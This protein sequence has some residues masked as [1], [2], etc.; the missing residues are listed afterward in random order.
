MASL[1]SIVAALLV[2]LLAGWLIW[3]RIL[4]S[5]RSAA[6][7]A[8]PA[9]VATE[10]A[11][12]PAA[13]SAVPA[14]TPAAEVKPAPAATEPNVETPE[15]AGKLPV[16][17]V[18][19]IAAPEPV[20]AAEP[21]AEPHPVAAPEPVAPAEPVAKPEPVAV[22]EPVAIAEPIAKPEPVAAAA[23]PALAQP[24]AAEPAAAEPVAAEPA[25]AEPVAAEPVA[26]PVAAAEPA[27]VEPE[28]V[29]AP[30]GVGAGAARPAD[31]LTRIEG[32]GPKIAATLAAAGISTYRDLAEADLASL[33]ATIKAAKLRLSPNLATW[34]EQARLLA[35]GD[36]RA[37][38]ALADD[39]AADREP[40]VEP[41]AT[42][43]ATTPAADPDL[44]AA[45]D[46]VTG[47]E[48]A[49][50]SGLAAPTLGS[51]TADDTVPADGATAD[52][53]TDAVPAQRSAEPT[54]PDDLTRIEGIGPKMAGALVAAGITT[55]AQ[56]AATDEAGLRAAIAAAGMRFSPSL[57]TWP[58]QAKLLADR[59]VL[60]S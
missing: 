43:S 33:R 46:S 59:G 48:P 9:A 10:P 28:P 51:T 34:P 52:E 11:E 19:P 57:V 39:L 15:P 44:I 45:T 32:I 7:E 18:E 23:E 60:R 26:E 53:A 16:A 2:G 17:D 56:L 20:A 29:A 21:V 40:G 13:A 36:Q 37:F 41:I 50:T 5:R 24:L 27:V 35:E 25:A 47:S 6:A 12:T 22:A 14:P 31:K 1:L 8:A 54:A 42:T 55:Y 49:A 38:T 4:V 3:G 30:G 58:Q